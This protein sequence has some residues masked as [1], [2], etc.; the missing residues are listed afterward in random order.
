MEN[1]DRFEWLVR[2]SSPHPRVSIIIPCFRQAQYLGECLASLVAQTCPAWE[3][4]VVDDA[5]PD[6]E[7]I[8]KTIQ[9]LNDPRVG[10]IRHTE[11]RGL[12]ATRNT[13]AMIARSDSLAFV[14]SDDLVY[15]DY[16][17]CMCSRL[18]LGA[19][20][21]W[22]YLEAFGE[23]TGLVKPRSGF[24]YDALNY[25]LPGAGALMRRNV[26]RRVGGYC[27]EPLFRLG[28]EERDFWISLIPFDF[29][30]AHLDRPVYRYRRYPGSMVSRVVRDRYRLHLRI[31]ERHPGV[32]ADSRLRRAFLS[33]GYLISSRFALA[34]GNSRTALRLAALAA[35]N[36]PNERTVLSNLVN[37]LLPNVKSR[38]HVVSQWCKVQHSRLCALTWAKMRNNP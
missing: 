33:S 29:Q 19:D 9:S 8:T 28:L 14:D 22:G 25:K 37:T 38:T 15:R 23:T 13:G 32:F 18:E 1:N 11:N 30:I 2:P 12:P 16:V 24:M 5:S 4:V 21:V 3:A 26:W 7:D 27:E 34:S 36:A 10:L 35:F 17:D 6:G 31:V 20:V